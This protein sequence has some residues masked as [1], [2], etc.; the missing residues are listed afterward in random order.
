MCLTYFI[1]ITIFISAYSDNTQK[2]TQLCS[3]TI[4]TAENSKNIK[5]I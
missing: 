1:K 5:F 4:Y 3:V 2:F